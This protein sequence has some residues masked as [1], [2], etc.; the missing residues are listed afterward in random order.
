MGFPHDPCRT[1]TLGSVLR[2]TG[3]VAPMVVAGP[4]NGDWFEAYVAQV[5]IPGLR[6]GDV[7]ILDT[8]SS[9][10]RASVRE[11]IEAVSASL[12]LLPLHSPDPNSIGMAFYRLKVMLRK[13]GERTAPA[14]VVSSA[15]SPISARQTNAPTTSTCEDIIQ[16]GR[17][18]L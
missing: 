5:L 12:S 2:M 1:T 17:T 18:T 6:S 9:H 8:L 11:R 16:H 13:A 10:K 3:M 14:Y 15:S 4:I 7:V